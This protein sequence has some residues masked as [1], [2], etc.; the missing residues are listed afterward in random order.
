MQLL[1]EPELEFRYG[2]RALDPRDGLSLFGP[3]DADA[4]SH[5]RGVVYGV[6]GTGDGIRRLRAWSKAFVAPVLTETRTSSGTYKYDVRN[7]PHF[8]GFEAAYDSKWPEEPAWAHELDREAISQAVRN[9][10]AHLRAARVVD[11]Y[12]EGIEIAAKRDESFGLLI[13]IV[14]DEV[15]RSC[16]PESVV[17]DGVGVS[18]S[19]KE[20]ALRASIPELFGTYDPD[21]YR[22]SVDF[23][24]QLKA[25]VMVHGTPIQIIRES[26]LDFRPDDDT[27]LTRDSPRSAVAWF[28][29]TAMYYKAGGK[30]WRL[31]SAR[32]GV[33]YIGFAF[34]RPERASAS[35]SKTAC[36]AAQMFL[37]T[38]DGIV[39]KGEFGPWYSPDTKEYHL[40]RD[41]AQQL[42]TG[43]LDTYAKLGGKP[44]TEIFL[45]SR[46]SIYDEEFAGYSKAC[47]RGVKLTGI[48][49]RIDDRA[50]KLFRPG[51]MPV[52]RGTFVPI[53][54]RSCYLWSS[55]F[56]LRLE[57]YD[58]FD[59][60]HPLRIDIQHGAGDLAQVAQDIL[61]LTKLNYNTCR[62]G[63]AQPVT[64]GFSNKVGEI[65]VTN[66]T[67]PGGRPQFKFYI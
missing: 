50:M 37:D 57:T 12:L 33:C 63:E 39:F 52:L 65:L 60:P 2:Q 35:R 31:C 25:R 9:L 27:G 7:W 8:P 22:R 64:V 56:K 42:L 36:C 38:G 5:P 40:D 13:C 11:M 66:P 20:R 34:R 44:L 46:S 62:L 15:W 47:P 6:I 53:S 45:H 14:P 49:V 41:A 30:P 24:R 55:G 16:R 58:G 23:R 3:Y 48:R 29:S 51:R 10:D 19:K 4:S 1:P 26:T 28:L 18:V 43:V 21:E 32:E 67:I 61:G 59:V 54:D 17:T